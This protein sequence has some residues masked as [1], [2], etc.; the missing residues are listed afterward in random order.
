MN[1]N[2]I[3]N[4]LE[5]K[6]ISIME[7][8]L[9]GRNYDETPVIWIS[10]NDDDKKC[11]FTE[12]LIAINEMITEQ[13]W[14]ELYKVGFDDFSIEK[15][16]YSRLKYSVSF[17]PIMEFSI[18]LI[19]KLELK[20]G[21]IY[22]FLE[23]NGENAMTQRDYRRFSEF[24]SV[25]K[26]IPNCWIIWIDH[27]TEEMSNNQDLFMMAIKIRDKMSNSVISLNTPFTY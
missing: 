24:C 3:P 9:H 22:I 17:T 14:D 23:P 4:E 12:S 8:I 25:I 7:R 18:G 15:F 16:K 5:S 13:R 2:F 19:D 10:G 1:N 26:E 20:T 27:S 11:Q 6:R 21:T